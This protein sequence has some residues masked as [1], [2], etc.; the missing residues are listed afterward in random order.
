MPA[1]APGRIAVF[2]V[3]MLLNVKIANAIGYFVTPNF[4]NKQIERMDS[5]VATGRL[6][7]CGD[8]A[9][10]ESCDFHPFEP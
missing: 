6:K 1:W 8:S 10:A 9:V 5:A 4:V 3:Q 2:G 7:P